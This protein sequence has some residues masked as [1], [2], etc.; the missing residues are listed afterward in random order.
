MF[1]P[2]QC[3][4]AAAGGDGCG[5]ANQECK[6]ISISPGNGGPSP[7]Q[8]LSKGSPHIIKAIKASDPS[9]PRIS[10]ARLFPDRVQTGC[11]LG[12]NSS[13]VIVHSCSGDT[14]L[15]TH[16]RAWEAHDTLNEEGEA[17]DVN[18]S[19]VRDVWWQ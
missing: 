6:H 18:F 16:I 12:H 5:V 14:P 4:K 11:L 3:V 15:V 1:R 8:L 2:V 9:A 10:T 13:D 19:P 17:G 7:R